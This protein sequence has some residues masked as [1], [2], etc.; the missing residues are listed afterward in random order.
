MTTTPSIRAL[1][2]ISI[3]ALL[4]TG[5]GRAGDPLKPSKAARLQAKENKQPPPPAP[6][7][8]KNNPDK[9]FILDGL[10]E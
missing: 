8:N 2:A 4:L 9:R 7:P 1:A 6:L 10:L 3:A 5:C